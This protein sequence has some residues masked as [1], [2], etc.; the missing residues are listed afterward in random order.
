[1]SVLWPENLPAPVIERS[2]H[3][4]ICSQIFWQSG[5]PHGLG[6]MI[7]LYLGPAIALRQIAYDFHH[8]RTPSAVISWAFLSD[9]VQSEYIRDPKRPLHISEGNEG[10]NL[11]IMCLFGRP[12]S[13]AALLRRT[14][15]NRFGSHQTVSGYQRAAN[16]VVRRLLV[17][18]RYGASRR[19]EDVSELRTIVQDVRFDDPRRA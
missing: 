9:D 15:N 8:G 7:P 12:G 19:C 6:W 1:M 2:T 3:I 14:L 11:W 18:N 17:R 4:G 16:G 13:R 10:T 5:L